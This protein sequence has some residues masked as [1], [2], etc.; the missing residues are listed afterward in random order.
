M[1]F[2]YR[3][4]SS[5]SA[6]SLTNA[7][8]GTRWRSARPAGGRMPVA[9]DIVVSWG[10]GPVPN[11]PA[12]VQ[13]LNGVPLGNK[14][15]DATTLQTAGVATVEVSRQRPAPPVAVP[16]ADPAI[17]AWQRAQDLAGEFVEIETYS[18]TP[19]LLRGIGELAISL[20]NLSTALTRPAPV[21]VPAQVSGE[22]LPRMFN[23]V[24]GNDL[25]TPPTT[26]DYFSRKLN[27]TDEYRVHS[28]DGKSI[29]AGRKVLRDG[30]QLPTAGRAL[31]VGVQPASPWIR[32][33]DGGWRINYD[34]FESS[35]AMRDLA[36]AAVTA[37]GLNFGAVDLGLTSDNRLVV[38][39]VNRA[40][41]LEGNT[42]E[43]Y[44]TAITRWVA[45][46]GTAEQRRAAA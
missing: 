20:N 36:A 35:R 29:R 28:F 26:P 10:G 31:P 18:R 32:S 4:Q 1:I 6:R 5:V 41:G 34:G 38:L 37:L 15:T 11:L 16:T 14:L 46:H 44:A 9:G 40:A 42:I 17:A 30:F 3:P 25:L 12:G 22:W 27:L 43:A 21:A 13:V 8:E 23:H 2:V 39:E 45:E 33:F 19:V 24:G 7:V